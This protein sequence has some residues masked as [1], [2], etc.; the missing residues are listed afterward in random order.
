MTFIAQK[1]TN[2]VNTLKNDCFFFYLNVFSGFQ[3]RLEC[4]SGFVAQRTPVIY[5][6]DGAF[7]KS[8]I[9]LTDCS[10]CQPP[11]PTTFLAVNK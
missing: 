5:C 6:V 3:C 10:A 2:L 9:I 1:V 8:V 7:A 11:L 4:D